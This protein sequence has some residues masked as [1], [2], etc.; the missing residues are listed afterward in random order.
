LQNL[1][2]ELR[3]VIAEEQNPAYKSV[4]VFAQY[5][6]LAIVE[7]RLVCFLKLHEIC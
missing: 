3:A 5:I 1:K 7:A 6:N 2:R 4:L